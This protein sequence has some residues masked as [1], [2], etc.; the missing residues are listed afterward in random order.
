M[1][2]QQI[3]QSGEIT[4]KRGAGEGL[5]KYVNVKEYKAELLDLPKYQQEASEYFDKNH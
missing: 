3:L 4:L 5:N 2:W 1:K